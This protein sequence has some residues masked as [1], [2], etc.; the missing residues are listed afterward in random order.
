[1]RT[2]LFFLFLLLP[3]SG[4]IADTAPDPDNQV[5]RFGV[6]TRTFPAAN[7]NDVLA[8]LR[9]W[10]DTIIRE[11]KLPESVEI[12]LYDSDDVL[13]AD[14]ARGGIDAASLTTEDIMLL[15]VRPEYIFIPTTDQGFEARYVLLAHRD[16]AVTDLAN[17]PNHK[18]AFFNN[19]R[20]ILA[21]PWLKTLLAKDAGQPAERLLMN[22]VEVESPS[23]AILQV[24]FGQA[25]TAL[26][27]LEAFELACEL[28]PQLRQ[29]LMVLHESQPF[30]T[31]FFVFNPDW[32]G[33]ARDRVEEAISSAHETPGGQQV[34][35]VFQ[36]SRMTRQPVSI[37]D[38]TLRFVMEYRKLVNKL[39]PREMV[40]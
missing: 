38:S 20:T 37:L 29:N 39:P 4:V 10:T 36:S 14:F 16:G 9:V 1:M 28:N 6:S 35:T 34:L 32:R 23:R 40:P 19:Q 11:R 17:I 31:T 2:L 26:V 12:I 18:L 5:I 22:L 33:T 7:R 8:A 25:Q 15:G 27:T 24:F 3:A 21:L 30:V 13:R